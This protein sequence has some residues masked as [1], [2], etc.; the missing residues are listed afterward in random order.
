MTGWQSGDAA[1]KRNPFKQ[2]AGNVKAKRVREVFPTDEIAH[3]WA[4]QTQARGRNAQGNLYFEGATLYSYG[5]HFPIGTIYERRGKGSLVLLNSGKYSNTTGGHQS[6]AA[7][8]VR[9][10][11]SIRVPKP[12]AGVDGGYLAHVEN[13]EYLIQSAAGY[14]ASAQRV[15]RV[16]RIAW[17]RGAARC[18][19][20]DAQRYVDYFGVRRKVPAFPEI[21]WNAAAARAERI[22]NPDPASLDKRERA[23]AKRLVRRREQEKQRA[24]RMAFEAMA[25]RSAWRLGGEWGNARSRPRIRSRHAASQWR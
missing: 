9:H 25:A 13:F 10:L 12:M 23:K 1:P 24:E 2:M 4:H 14:L 5:S 19:L 20:T 16:D 15:H 3:K 11:H 6:D 8:S 7:Q 17:M 18:C 21:T 22:E